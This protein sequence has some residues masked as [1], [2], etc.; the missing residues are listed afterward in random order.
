MSE[1]LDRRKRKTRQ[2]LRLALIALMK[3]KGLEKIT[4][5]D[6][7]ER[8][9]MNR[10]TFY[11][12]YQDVPDLF[13]QVKQEIFDDMSKI[14]ITF[15]P[16]EISSYAVEDKPYPKVIKFLTYIAENKDFFLVIFGPNGDAGFP[17][18]IKAFMTEHL[19]K[20]SAFAQLNDS[21]KALVPRDYL[22]AYVSSANLGLITHWL[23]AGLNLSV[24]EV[25]LILTRIMHKGPIAI[26]LSHLTQS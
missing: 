13:L 14:M 20:K 8:A 2:Q 5:S 19:Y 21:G 6:L 22:I 25:A 24:E 1:K 9:D 15:D 11:L 26:T 4:V 12:H 18:Q 7:T 23:N 10:G 3:E 16:R 17:M